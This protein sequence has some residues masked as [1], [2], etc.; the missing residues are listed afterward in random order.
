MT[1]IPHH[2][3]NKRSDSL[4]RKMIGPDLRKIT[5]KLMHES[6]DC[7][8]TDSRKSSI[9]GVTRWVLRERGKGTTKGRETERGVAI[10]G[11]G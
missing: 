10:S 7:W 8:N 1:A 2:I 3:S 11:H 9:F 6:G 5:L 4:L